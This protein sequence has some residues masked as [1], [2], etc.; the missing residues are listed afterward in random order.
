M[1]SLDYMKNGTKLWARGVTWVS[2]VLELRTGRGAA[3]G[4]EESVHVF[5]APHTLLSTPAQLIHPKGDFK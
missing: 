3:S 2:G 5:V 1:S 4:T